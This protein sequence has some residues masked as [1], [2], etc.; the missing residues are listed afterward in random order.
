MLGISCLSGATFCCRAVSALAR[1]TFVH[2]IDLHLLVFIDKDY[3]SKI[4]LA[5]IGDK[6]SIANCNFNVSRS[7]FWFFLLV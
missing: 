2:S 6:H 4:F 7:L 3:L 5:I 1:A